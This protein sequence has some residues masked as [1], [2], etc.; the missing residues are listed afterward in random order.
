MAS[1]TIALTMPEESMP[2]AEALAAARGM[3]VSELVAGLLQ[4]LIDV[5]GTSSEPE[6]PP[7]LRGAVA[8]GTLLAMAYLAAATSRSSVTPEQGGGADDGRR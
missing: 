4:Q 3:S 8:R 7:A 1:K 6:V 2:R 5:K